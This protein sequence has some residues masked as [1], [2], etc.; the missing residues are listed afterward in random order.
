MTSRPR[1]GS[2]RSRTWDDAGRRHM[3]TN[4]GFGL[5]IVA[6]LL[7]LA[8]AG[9][10]AWYSAHMAPAV[11][12]ND[13][14]LTKDDVGRQEKVNNFLIGYQRQRTRNLLSSGHLWATDANGRLTSLD[15]QVSQVQ[16]LSVNQLTDGTVMLDL[17]KQQGVPVTAAD[18]AARQTDTATQP[19]LRHVWQIVVAPTLATGETTATDAEKAAAKAKADAALAS[20]K[21]GADWATVAKATSTDTATA[22]AG[23]DVGY[24][25]KNSSLDTAFVDALMAAT[26]NI[27]TDVIEGAD[28]SYRIGRVTDVIAPQVDA[29]FADQAKSAGISQ[30]DLDWSFKFA[31]ASSKLQDYVVNQAMAAAPQR[32]VY[33]IYMQTSASETGPSAIRVRHILYSPNHDPNTASTVRHHRSGVGRGQGAR[34]RRVQEAPGGPDAVRRA[35][36]APRATSRRP[37][38]A[39]ASCPTSPPTTASTR[40]SPTAIFQP[41]LQ[42][43]QLLAPVKSAFGWHVIQ[44]MHGPDRRRLG[45]QADPAGH[46]PRRVQDARP[47]QLG[48]RRG[49]AGRRHGLDRPEHVP[50]QRPGRP[51]DLRGAGGQ[52][53]PGRSRC[54][55]TGPT[56]SGSPR[57]RPACRTAPRPSP[58]SPTPSPR[59]TRPSG[60]RTRSGRTRR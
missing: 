10:V 52:G 46:Q 1:Q 21:G 5:A 47:R 37:R 24:V 9:G 35:W 45:E 27:P 60:P 32:H 13:V 59:G 48:Q 51:G 44:V 31:A 16:S 58:S 17:A 2:S 49:G 15:S 41:G 6:A 23:G 56:C 26:P 12:V 7:L 39:A 34:R 33:Q 57:S 36:R 8:I 4:L 55:V 54:P 25:D 11:T 14:T 43:G 3:L 50:G 19:E 29:T 22:P 53:Q 42:P 28:G 20:L 38:R 18:I 40:R 30:D